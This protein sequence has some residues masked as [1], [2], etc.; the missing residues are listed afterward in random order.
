MP[1]G[2]HGEPNRG[3]IFPCLQ[4]G[5]RSFVY[6]ILCDLTVLGRRGVLLAT[7]K[8]A[9]LLGTGLLSFQKLQQGSATK[10]LEEADQLR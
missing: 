4:L 1:E 5:S 9:L 8:G 7:R 2:S 10:V 6:S 3:D